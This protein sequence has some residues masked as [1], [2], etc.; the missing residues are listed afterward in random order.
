MEKVRDLLQP[1]TDNLLIRES[2]ER[3]IWIADATEVYVQSEPEML[4]ILQAGVENRSIAS[5]SILCLQI[6]IT[7]KGNA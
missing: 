7:L 1:G 2:P 3:G 5:T 4:Q 6:E